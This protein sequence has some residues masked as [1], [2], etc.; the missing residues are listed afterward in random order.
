MYFLY[1]SVLLNVCLGNL[2]IV[3]YAHHWQWH[4]SVSPNIVNKGHREPDKRKSILSGYPWLGFRREMPI[5]L[6]CFC[7]S[8]L[9]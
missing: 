6:C 3:C 5:V 7:V 4:I 1:L 8:L 2:A 9:C